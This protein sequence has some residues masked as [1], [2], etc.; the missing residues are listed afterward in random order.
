MKKYPT[1]TSGTNGRLL[2]REANGLTAAVE[3]LARQRDVPRLLE[4]LRNFLDR[5]S[6]EKR[7]EVTARGAAAPASK[8]PRVPR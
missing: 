7:G 8:V 6:T 2:R 4:E 3:N 5:I 1:D